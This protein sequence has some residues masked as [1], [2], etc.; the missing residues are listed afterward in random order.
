MSGQSFL[1]AKTE[2]KLLLKASNA[3]GIPLLSR[4]LKLNYPKNKLVLQK[5]RILRKRQRKLFQNCANWTNKQKPFS[6]ESTCR[7]QF[8]YP[9]TARKLFLKADNATGNPL[10]SRSFK[11]KN[12]RNKLI[13]YKCPYSIFK[14]KPRSKELLNSVILQKGQGKAFPNQTISKEFLYCQEI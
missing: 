7:E 2:G 8:L 12:L 1:F 4:N 5:C 10:L 11:L 6:N 3:K 9:E 14:K 13:P